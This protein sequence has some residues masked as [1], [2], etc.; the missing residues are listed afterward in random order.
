[1]NSIGSMEGVI[2]Y[3]RR[4]TRR[5]LDAKACLGEPYEVGEGS[6]RRVLLWLHPALRPGPAP[7]V[8]EI[9][10][11]GFALGDARKEDALCERVRDEF[12][13]HVVGIDY[14]L[15]PEHPF[16]AALEDVIAAMEVMAKGEVAQ[17]DTSRF[18][19]LGYS[20]GANLA[21]SAAL[22]CQGRLDFK[23]AG[24]ALH[25]PFLDAA[26]PVPIEAARAMDLPADLMA[27]FN[28]W[29]AAD[30]DP[31]QPAISPVRA[32]VEQLAALPAVSLRPVVGDALFGQAK[33]MR[34]RM[35]AAGNPALWHPVDGVYHG[36]IED[37]ADL[38]TYRAISLPQTIEGRPSGFEKTAWRQVAESLEDIMGPPPAR[39]CDMQEGGQGQ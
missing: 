37:A 28:E 17:V 30:A 32:P 39:K 27:A 10:G 29:Y 31:A 11:G 23:V 4:A 21:L 36:Y 13:A 15:A 19:L 18:Y 22:A 34:D 35:E 3:M 24:L 1:M 16:P 5:A 33:L 20:A 25:Y 2:R 14:R 7:V 38:D 6:S 12:C 26:A 9:H 8:F